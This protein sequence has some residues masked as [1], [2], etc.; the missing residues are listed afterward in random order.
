MM[1]C[2]PIEDWVWIFLGALIVLGL[3]TL[4][5]VWKSMED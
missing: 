2:M 1:F 4:Y 5:V 3:V